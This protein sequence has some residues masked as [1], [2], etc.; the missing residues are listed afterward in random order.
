MMRVFAVALDLLY[1]AA[2]RRWF[3]ALGGAITLFLIGLALSLQLDVVEGTLAATR[4]FGDDISGPM[5]A[6]DVVLRPLYRA[7]AYVIFFGGIVFGTLACA[8]FAP[9]L[10]SPG[11]IEHLLSLPVRRVELIAGTFLGVLTI[12]I[13]GG[14]YGALGFTVVLGVKSGIWTM[15]PLYSAVLAGIGFSA[16]YGAMLA[17]AT[18]VRSAALSAAVGAGVLLAGIISSFRADLASLFNPGIWRGIF[19]AFTALMPRFVTLAQ[20]S[21]DIAA[22]APLSMGALLRLLLGMLLFGVS[23]TFVAAWRI[24]RMDF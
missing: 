2:R 18:F 16:I 24:E 7:C 23:M 6:V 9:S 20:A 14:L 1:E 15:G 21:A 5:Q 19:E 12:A 8:D 17:A 13:I 3:L 4:L 22:S 10:L 11:R